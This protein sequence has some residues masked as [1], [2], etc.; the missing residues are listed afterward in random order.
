ML[1]PLRN[2][3][4]PRSRV[5]DIKNFPAP[6]KGWVADSEAN[7][8]SVDTARILVNM[9]PRQNSIYVRKGSKTIC[10][11]TGA[12]E[13]L[14]NFDKGTEEILVAFTDSSMYEIPVTDGSVIGAGVLIEDGFS[15]GRWQTVM[16]SNAADDIFLVCVNGEDGIWVYDGTTMV[17]SAVPATF[18][19]VSNVT[20]FKAR[21]W[22]TKGNDQSIYYG[23]VLSANPATLTEFP[24][25]PL[26]RR[27]GYIVALNSLSMDGGSGPD[28]YLVAVSSRGEIIVYSGIDPADDFALVGIF[29]AANPLGKRCLIKSGSDLLYYS[30]N[31]PQ[32]MSRLFSTIEGIDS[33]SVPI[34]SEFENAIFTNNR[35]FGW[36]MISYNKRGWVLFNVPVIGYSVYNQFVLSHESQA[37]FKI[38]DWNA[39]CFAVHNQNLYFADSTGDIKI[40]DFG[41]SD[42]DKAILFD[43]MQSWYEFEKV[44]RKKFNMA[45]VTIKATSV[46]KITVDM[47]V[48]YKET[49]PTSQPGF[50]AE[51]VASPWNVSPWDTSPWSGSAVF[52]VNSFG[53]SN[54]GF[55]GALRYRGQLKNSSHELMGFRI[56]F[57]EGSFL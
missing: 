2:Q 14:A 37:W 6:V 33:V 46:P 31:G 9:V 45:Q 29:A 42:D 19:D 3:R 16:M 56:A 54:L 35:T 55:V 5:S 28:D 8:A 30:T 41:E 43:Y 13:T 51:E 38:T 26:L 20:S 40:A 27:G 39:L 18:N 48:D 47:N 15:N 4:A 1:T 7:G 50:A 25:G 53:L 22:F 44:G 23:D 57:E 17:K 24:L 32:L 21:L 52:Y 11:L 10:K 49:Q 34:R 36:E 12:V